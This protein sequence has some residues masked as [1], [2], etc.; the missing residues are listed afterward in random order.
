MQLTQRKKI[1]PQNNTVQQSTETKRIVQ[2]K[3][4]KW[5]NNT[6]TTHVR[7]AAIQY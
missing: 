5:W 2:N 7:N 6:D 3:I 1:R 4:L